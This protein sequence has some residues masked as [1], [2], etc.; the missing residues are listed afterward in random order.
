MKTHITVSVNKK[1]VHIRR[2]MTVKHALVACDQG[3]YE[4]AM[5]GEISLEDAH[6]FQIGLD[7]GLEDG[8]EIVTRF[9]SR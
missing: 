4:A 8:A 5:K 3:L 9:R 6:G 1:Q 7:G 2:G